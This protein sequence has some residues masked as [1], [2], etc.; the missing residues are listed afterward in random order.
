MKFK[1]IIVLKLLI[2]FFLKYLKLY[3]PFLNKKINYS[4]I[5]KINK[6]SYKE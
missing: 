6:L 2:K 1:K 5:I 3:N 4:E